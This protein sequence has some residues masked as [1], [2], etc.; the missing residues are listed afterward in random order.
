LE[1]LLT[2][3]CP[4]CAGSAVVK[5]RS[6][7]CS[8]ILSEMQ[9]IGD[10]LDGRGVRLCVNP[11]I[12]RALRGEERDVFAEIERFLGRSVTLTSDTQ[13]HHEQFDVMAM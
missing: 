9:K 5:S 4:Y 12:A 6:T 10:A 2:E 8:D 7:I 11:D 1:R 3:P 13:L